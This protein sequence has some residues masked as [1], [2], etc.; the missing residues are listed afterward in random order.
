MSS[1]QSRA[2]GNRIENQGF[3]DAAIQGFDWLEKPGQGLALPVMQEHHLQQYAWRIINDYYIIT[4]TP[5]YL[6]QLNYF[7][8]DLELRKWLRASSQSCGTFGHENAIH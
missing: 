8:V 7:S 2:V 5:R 4:N 3:D 1:L 6:R